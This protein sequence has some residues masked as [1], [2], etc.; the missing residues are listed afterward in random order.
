MQC[1]VKIKVS[2][3]EHQDRQSGVVILALFVVFILLLVGAAFLF[4]KRAQDKKPVST[5]AAEVVEAG[6]SAISRTAQ[7]TQRKNDASILLEAVAEYQ[8]NNT[9]YLPNEISGSMLK[10]MGYYT[11]ASVAEGE[12]GPVTTDELRLVK[13]ARCLAD[14]ATASGSS[15]QYAAQYSYKNDDGTFDPQCKDV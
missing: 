3:L 15:R 12:Q 6:G 13:A 1:I 9:G 11:S 2:K 4:V 7:N 8:A 5:T 14:G 10:G